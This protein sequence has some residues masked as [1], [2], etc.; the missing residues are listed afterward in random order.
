MA[1]AAFVVGAILIS[2]H[3]AGAVGGAEREARSGA[4]ERVR[5]LDEIT[6]EG[7]IPLP[8]VLFIASR[9][10]PSYADLVHR[11][12]VRSSADVGRAT[13]LPVRVWAP[14][15]MFGSGGV[16]ADGARGKRGPQP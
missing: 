6:I 9:E 14:R 13:S 16:G 8:Q 15:G 3:V 4:N 7:E 12:F 11:T 5:T 10:Q 1:R 2:A